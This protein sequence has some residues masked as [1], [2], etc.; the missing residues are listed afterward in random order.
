MTLKQYVDQIE[1]CFDRDGN[2]ERERLE[3]ILVLMVNQA[4]TIISK[5]TEGKECGC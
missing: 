1:D 3:A 2:C 5:G 4:I